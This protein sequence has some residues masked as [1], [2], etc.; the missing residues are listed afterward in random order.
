MSLQ[1]L[2][3]AEQE[4]LLHMAQEELLRIYEDAE[5]ASYYADRAAAID[6]LQSIIDKLTDDES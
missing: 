6:K 2:T 4:E 5:H 1:D 3:P